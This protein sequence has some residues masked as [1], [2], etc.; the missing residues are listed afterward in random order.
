MVLITQLPFPLRIKTPQLKVNEANQYC[1]MFYQC[2]K[3][4]TNK[5]GTP[6]MIVMI[7]PLRIIVTVCLTLLLM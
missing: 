5:D 2:V 4:V 6:T 3:S 1:V 7:N